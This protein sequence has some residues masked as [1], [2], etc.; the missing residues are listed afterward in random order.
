MVR[1]GPTGICLNSVVAFVEGLRERLSSP[2]PPSGLSLRF[3]CKPREYVDFRR[4]HPLISTKSAP[5]S[6]HI[7]EPQEIRA[8]HGV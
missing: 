4:R 1:P 7:I 8:A 6:I 3:A 5:H 2:R